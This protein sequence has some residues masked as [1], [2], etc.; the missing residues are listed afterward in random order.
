M[1]ASIARTLTLLLTLPLAAWSSATTDSPLSTGGST[2]TPT[3]TPPFSFVA[4]GCMPYAR[5]PGSEAGYGRVLSEINRHAPVFAIHL[6][7]IM[8]GEE[9]CT[10]DLLKRRLMEFDSVATAMIFTPGDNEWTDVHRTLKYQPLERLARIRE[11]F[12][13]NEFSRGQRPLALVSQRR[14][15]AFTKYVENVRWSHGKVL[16]A[17]VH[18]VGS[19]NNRQANVPGAIE[20]WTER[21]QANAAWLRE[22]MTEARAAEAPGVVFFCQANP[23][24]DN[25]AFA[26]FLETLA[27]ECLAYGKPVLLVHADEHRYRLEPGFRPRKDAAPIPNLT[28]VETF[29]A[30]DLHGVLIT[31]DPSSSAVFLPGPMIVPGNPLPRLPRPAPTST[32]KPAL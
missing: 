31:V 22:T 32:P 5:L 29:G 27:N 17:T 28:R 10:D 12:F 25:P 23:I 7:D 3:P 1:H 13:A 24:L 20:E 30:S 11:L 6:G 18:V 19:N 2:N 14:S 8:G 9:L 15:P 26:L 4:I 21:D 16:F